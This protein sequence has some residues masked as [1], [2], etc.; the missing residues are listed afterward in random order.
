LWHGHTPPDKHRAI[1]GMDHPHL[2]EGDR[3]GLDGGSA[4]TGIV[5]PRKSRMARYRILKAGFRSSTRFVWRGI[6]IDELHYATPSLPSPRLPRERPRHS[7]QAWRRRRRGS[8]AWRA[9][10]GR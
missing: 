1:S 9:A 10:D 7:V 6:A 4:R 2:F 8:R 3:L 5:T